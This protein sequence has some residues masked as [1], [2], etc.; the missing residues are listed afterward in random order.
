M[1]AASVRL[2]I[3]FL[4]LFLFVVILV[5][6]IREDEIAGVEERA[7]FGPDVYERRLNS[8]EDRFDFPEIH[9]P[10]RAAVVGAIEHQF[11]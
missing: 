10:D 3:L 11:Y 8:G 5:G 6:F 2:A 9:I 7:L 4:A 1:A